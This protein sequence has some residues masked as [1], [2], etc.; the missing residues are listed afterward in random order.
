MVGT[1][2]T[3]K[4]SVL[5]PSR[6]AY[7]KESNDLTL[8][9]LYAGGAAL[10]APQRA[11]RR[12]REQASCK[13][14]LLTRKNYLNSNL[15]SVEGVERAP[16]YRRRQHTENEF[17]HSISRH[18]FCCYRCDRSATFS[19]RQAWPTRPVIR[20]LAAGKGAGSRLSERSSVELD[21]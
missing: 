21:F 14:K 19:A 8:I 20:I 15:E 10:F 16:Y 12:A 9:G 6:A 4:L 18:R 3:L 2:E 13:F 7:P 1:A 17:L 5:A 11:R